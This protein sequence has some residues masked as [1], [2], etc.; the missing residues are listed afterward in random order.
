MK[1]SLSLADPE[2]STSK[3]EEEVAGRSVLEQS[4]RVTGPGGIMKP[5]QVLLLFTVG[6][7]CA[8]AA[9]ERKLAYVTVVSKV[10]YKAWR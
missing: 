6:S 5:A 10:S 8:R 1:L 2:E 4:E 7:V 3:Q 9:A